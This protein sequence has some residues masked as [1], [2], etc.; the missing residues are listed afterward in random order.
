[1]DIRSMKD[2]D[3]DAVSELYLAAYRASWSA[4]GARAYIEKFYRFEPASCQVA[5]DDGRVAGAIL[6][7]TFERETG[8][9]LYIQELM[10]HPDFQS[11]GIGKKLVGK[12]R[13]ALTK[14]PSKV[15]ITPLVKAD[16][17]V[18]NFYNSLG[19]DK[20][21]VVSFSLDIE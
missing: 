13:E 1:M 21:K 11:R 9:V 4:A 16:T 15:K 8:V 20:D 10:V 7:Y 3:L 6:A 14:G 19:F 17:T 12:L 5:L 2:G 18:L